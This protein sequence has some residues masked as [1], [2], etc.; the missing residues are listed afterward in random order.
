[1]CIGA[2]GTQ[3][4]R[5]RGGR[6]TPRGWYSHIQLQHTATHCY[7]PQHTATHCTTLQHAT[8]HQNNDTASR[9]LSIL[10]ILSTLFLLHS[11]FFLLNSVTIHSLFYSLYR[12]H[13]YSTYSPFSHYSLSLFPTKFSHYSLYRLHSWSIFSPFTHYSLSIHSIHSIPTPFSL[14]PTK[15]N[16]YSLSIHSNDCIPTIFRDPK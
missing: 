14:F 7:T 3:P 6:G 4:D 8:P 12:L 15:F 16:H 10:S 13:F 1:M 11:V 5:T 9:E 2:I